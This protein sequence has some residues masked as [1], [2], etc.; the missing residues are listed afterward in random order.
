MNKFPW[1][2]RKPKMRFQ[3]CKPGKAHYYKYTKE[4]KKNICINCGFDYDDL[5]K[6]IKKAE[7]AVDKMINDKLGKEEKENV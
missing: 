4:T 2:Y 3:S 7:A 5:L 6:D 1:V